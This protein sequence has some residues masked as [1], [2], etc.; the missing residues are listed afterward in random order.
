[1]EYSRTN[2]NETTIEKEFCDI[3]PNQ[4]FMEE[5]PWTKTMENIMSL[6]THSIAIDSEGQKIKINVQKLHV[7]REKWKVHAKNAL[8]WSFYVV[9]NKNI[10]DGRNTLDHVFYDLIC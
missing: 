8:F 1:M 10:I 6:Q 4:V 7:Q 3:F 2:E 5:V 9:N